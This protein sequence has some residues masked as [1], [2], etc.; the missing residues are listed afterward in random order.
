[1]KASLLA[2][3]TGWSLEQIA[4]QVRALI[5]TRGA[6]GSWIFAEGQRLRDPARASRAASPIRP[7]AAM[8]IAPDCCTA[9][10]AA[11][12]GT[13]T[14]RVAALLGAIKIEHHGTQQHRCGLENFS[15][16]FQAAFG[17]SL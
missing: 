1:M 2:E 7:A 11:W 8:P 3:R 9:W 15:D 12:T 6:E 10:S 14:G 17:Y 5:V 4:A 13:T 16:R